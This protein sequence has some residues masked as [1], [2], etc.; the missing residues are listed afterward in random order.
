MQVNS[1]VSLDTL[2]NTDI[3][4][5]HMSAYEVNGLQGEQRALLQRQEST[6][7]KNP[8]HWEFILRIG[9]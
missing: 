6:G 4:S 7:H 8:G 5:S 1:S 2:T 9:A 3:V